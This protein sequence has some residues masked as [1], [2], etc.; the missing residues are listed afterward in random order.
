[1]PARTCLFL[2]AIA[3]LNGCGFVEPFTPPKVVAGN[4]STLTLSTGSLRDAN[5][6]A[7]RYCAKY[8]KRAVLT[9]RGKMTER[10]VT[11]YL[12]DCLP[13]QTR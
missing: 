2:A 4:E 9:S 1:M 13:A 3:V 7:Q 5:T 8:G 6:Y 11:I 10:A 12:Y